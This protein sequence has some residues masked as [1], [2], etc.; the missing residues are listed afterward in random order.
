MV[1]RLGGQAVV[2]RQPRGGVARVGEQPRRFAEHLGVERHQ[3]VAQ[4]DVG[5][6][7]RE[8]AVRRAA[9]IVDRAVL[10][11]QPGDL[12]RMAHEVGRKLGR[13]H[14]VDALAVRFGQIDHPPCGGLRQQLFLRIPL[15]R[16][17]HA[18]G[19]VAAARQLVHEAAHEQLRAA[20]NTNGHCASHT[21]TVAVMRAAGL[22]VAG[23]ELK[24]CGFTVENEAVE[25]WPQ[26]WWRW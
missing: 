7:V 1:Q 20:A 3:P 24:E 12:V 16:H 18:L 21:S 6:R 15:E 9:E 26:H 10:M 23:R 14:R 11:E 2:A 17:R 13:D 19:A 8:L 25:G 22:P 5:F 4:P